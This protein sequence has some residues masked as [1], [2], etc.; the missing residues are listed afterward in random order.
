MYPDVQRKAQE[1][2][3][4]VVGPN[5]L[6]EYDDLDNLAYIRAIAMETMRWMPVFPLGLPHAVTQSDTYRG[7]HIP[8]GATVVAVSWFH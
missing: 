8:K 1:E 3:D 2:L 5:R 7:Y 6:P 4:R